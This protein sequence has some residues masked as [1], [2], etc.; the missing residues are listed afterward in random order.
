MKRYCQYTQIKLST[1][2]ILYMC[3]STQQY[4]LRN[5][6]QSISVIFFIIL[7]SLWPLFKSILKILQNKIYL[8]NGLL[9]SLSIQL[10]L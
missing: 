10:Q 7:K 1:L 2:F 5:Q 8:N 9:A 3:V 4:K 6:S